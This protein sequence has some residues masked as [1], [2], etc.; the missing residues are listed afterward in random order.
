MSSGLDREDLLPDRQRTMPDLDGWVSDVAVSKRW[1]VRPTRA[2]TRCMKG[3]PAFR[4]L[5]S[6]PAAV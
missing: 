1:H 2:E 4:F 6:H 5:P 3:C